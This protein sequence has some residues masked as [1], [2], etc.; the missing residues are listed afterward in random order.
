MLNLLTDSWMPVYRN[1]TIE[2]L[3]V[4]ELARYPEVQ[5]FAAPRADFNAALSQFCIGL[6][7]TTFTPINDK[8]WKQRFDTPPSVD[9][10]QAQFAPYHSAF[11]VTVGQRRFMQDMDLDTDALE[12][13]SVSSLLIDAPGGNALKENKDHFIKRNNDADSGMSLPM[14]ALAL[15]TLQLNAPSG[16]VGYRTSLRG[17]GPLTTLLLPDPNDTPDQDSLWHRLW[18]NVMTA[19]NL[20]TLNHAPHPGCHPKVLPWLAA[21]RTSDPKQ[22]GVDTTPEDAHALQAYW[23]M[24]RQV[25]LLTDELEDG[26]CPL[27]G[28]HG[29]LVRQFVTTNYGTNYTGAWL[30][31]LSPYYFKDGA[32]LPLHPQPG[33]FPYRHW[34]TLIMS[35]QPDKEQTADVIR[36]LRNRRFMPKRMRLWAAGY[37]MDNAKAR[38]WYEATLPVWQ[39]D[40]KTAIKLE[41]TMG[42]IINAT[43]QIANNLRAAVK[44]AWISKG[45][46]AKGDLSVV[47]TAFWQQTETAFYQLLSKLVTTTSADQDDSPLR[48]Q[49][50]NTLNHHSLKLF[51]QWALDEDMSN[52][53]QGHVE[54]GFANPGRALNARKNLIKFNLKKTIQQALRLPTKKTKK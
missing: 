23:G 44:D 51:D 43:E 53:G 26:I 47:Q 27:S 49:W 45:N 17:G 13:R 20:R 40:D 12:H 39:L 10:L 29:P 33:G 38:C 1:G 21:T 24:P 32:P 46:K 3:S 54:I 37:D 34:L 42:D 35:N 15:F 14:A 8:E 50:F 25:Q 16:G 4:T 9:T 18:L 5:N 48:Q 19:N 41:A 31:P 22:G 36:T 30:H 52:D 6:L 28:E 11:E 7:Q 2:T